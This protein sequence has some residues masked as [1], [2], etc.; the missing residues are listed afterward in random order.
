M[1]VFNRLTQPGVAADIDAN[2]AMV[3]AYPTLDATGRFGHD[4]T[5]NH[6]LAVGELVLEQAG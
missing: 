6:D 5:G 3:R 4:P 1:A 2:R